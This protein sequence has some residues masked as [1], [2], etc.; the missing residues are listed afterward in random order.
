MAKLGYLLLKQGKWEKQQLI[1]EEW[2]DSATVKHITA[3][4]KY[5]YGYQFW[6]SKN[7]GVKNYFFRGAYPP[8]K[9]IITVIPELNTVVVYVGEYYKT[10]EMLKDFIIPALAQLD[11]EK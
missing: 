6:I 5:D 8:S 7:I 2:I 4:D 11:I 10:D 9:K 3:N 1:P